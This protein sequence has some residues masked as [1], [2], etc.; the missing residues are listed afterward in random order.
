[1][2]KNWVD[3][4]HHEDDFLNAV[5]PNL[6]AR[7]KVRWDEDFVYIGA[8][9]QVTLPTNIMLI[10]LSFLSQFSRISLRFYLSFLSQFSRSSL[11]ISDISLLC[12]FSQEP[13]VHGTLTKH[14]D[15]PPY[16]DNDFEVF[17]DPSGSTQYYIEYEMNALN[18]TYD[19]KW[20]VPDGA[21]LPSAPACGACG[22]GGIG[23]VTD[24]SVFPTTV[25][26][27]FPGYPGNWTMKAAADGLAGGGMTTATHYDPDLFGVFTYP[28]T[29]WSLEIAFPLRSTPGYSSGVGDSRAPTA[30]GGL[31]DADP[32]RQAEYDTYDPNLGAAGPGRPRYWWAD[33]ARAEHTRQYNTSDGQAKLCPMNCSAE[34]AGGSIY[35]TNA[36]IS[37]SS[38]WFSVAFELI[39]GEMCA[40]AV[41]SGKPE[42][43]KVW[44]D[45]AAKDLWPTFLG[46]LSDKTS[47][48]WEFVWQP[49]G[50]A[51]PGV[52]YMHRPASWYD[53]STFDCRFTTDLL[54]F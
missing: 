28:A 5:P 33:F 34:L 42:V 4:T 17:L 35:G 8:E 48:Y 37:G 12:H 9:L 6:Q 2:M 19:I 46:R 41:W 7:V 11:V 43:P 49:V 54:H 13:W 38:W 30:H 50:I 20:G 10:S 36:A 44:A 3:I 39:V 47:C 25:N 40:D 1:M 29:T 22:G 15:V 51:N 23:N 18:A 26:T 21:D 27:S 31:L 14:N 16:M 53:L 52:G 45:D 32:T 24:W